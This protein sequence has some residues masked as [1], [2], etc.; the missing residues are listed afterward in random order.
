MSSTQAIAVA[1][2]WLAYQDALEAW[3]GN[4]Y[5][6]EPNDPGHGLQE[7]QDALLG[8][9]RAGEYDL[10]RSFY[11]LVWEH[12][13]VF[14]ENGTEHD[15]WLVPALVDEL[16]RRAVTTLPEAVTEA[17]VTI[18]PAAVT[19]ECEW[20]GEPL[21]SGLRLDARYCPGSRCRVAALR[22]RRDT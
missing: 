14:A 5:E 18:A 10:A 2:R 7:L 17:P 15:P 4:Q 9:T 13:G 8:L 20:C 21:P 16:E 6:Q 22:A 1:R 12:V 19:R 11:R 3:G